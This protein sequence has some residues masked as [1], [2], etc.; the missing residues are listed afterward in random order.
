MSDEPGR[1]RG[2]W[3]ASPADPSASAIPP[4]PGM[5]HPTGQTVN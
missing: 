2:R 3:G 4:P 1:K 5:G